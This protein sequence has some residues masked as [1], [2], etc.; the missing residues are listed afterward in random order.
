MSIKSIHFINRY[1]V[2]RQVARVIGKPWSGAKQEVEW[3]F[4][5]VDFQLGLGPC[6]KVVKDLAAYQTENTFTISQTHEDGTSKDFIYQMSDIAGR[7]VVEYT[8][9][10]S[11]V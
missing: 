6:G 7:I 3:V 9:D 2:I 5:R 1:P 8:E 11:N 4:A 10:D